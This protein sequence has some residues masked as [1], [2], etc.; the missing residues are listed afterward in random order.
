MYLNRVIPI[1]IDD[2]SFLE[3]SK[4]DILFLLPF[5][6]VFTEVSCKHWGSATPR[7]WE[8]VVM[9]LLER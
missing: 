4:T 3:V 9:F 5:L 7:K 1:S 6:G 2:I 8:L